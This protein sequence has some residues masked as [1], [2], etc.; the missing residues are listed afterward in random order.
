MTPTGPLSV[1]GG[2]SACPLTDAFEWHAVSAYHLDGKTH[3]SEL[4]PDESTVEQ[5]AFVFKQE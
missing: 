3:G 1:Q 2:R 4:G 5:F